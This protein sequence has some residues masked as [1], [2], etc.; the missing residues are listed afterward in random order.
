[1]IANHSC[2]A[3]EDA[4]SRLGRALLRLK[5]LEEVLPTFLKHEQLHFLRMYQLVLVD[6]ASKRLD[7][8]Q[9]FEKGIKDLK[10]ITKIQLII[11]DKISFYVS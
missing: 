11:A 2:E 3:I 8:C 4:G 10:E 6:E 9:A 7:T 5:Q 1:M